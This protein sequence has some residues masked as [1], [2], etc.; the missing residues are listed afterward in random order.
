MSTNNRFSFL[1][2]ALAITPVSSSFA[3]SVTYSDADFT[4]AWQ[5]TILSSALGGHSLT[6]TILTVPVD[7]NAPDGNYTHVDTTSG[8]LGAPVEGFFFDSGMV[9]DPAGMFEITSIDFSADMMRNGAAIISYGLLQNGTYYRYTG[10]N[11]QP[12][13]AW[14]A[15][16]HS[17]AAGVFGRTSL[18]SGTGGNIPDFSASGAPITIGMATQIAGFFSLS[19]GS[20]D[21]DNF[22][23]T[24]NYTQVPE[25]SALLF[26]LGSCTLL[27]LRRRK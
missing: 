10:L 9:F 19:S 3:L 22:S 14:N 23:A 13:A 17:L 26:V 16:S 12:S 15:Q 11:G 8:S 4:P 24:I 27:Q 20:A 18:V 6:Q 2:A 1:L 21:F 7:G 5:S 25:P